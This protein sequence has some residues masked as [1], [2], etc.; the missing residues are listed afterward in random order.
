MKKQ[1]FTAVLLGAAL[2]CALAVPAAAAAPKVDT[3]TC[4]NDYAG[5]LSQETEDYVTGITV[6]LQESCGA[7]IGVYTV[8]NIGNTDLE[9]Y[10]Y[11]VFNA[12]GLGDA[13]EDNGVLLL[14]TPGDDNYICLQGEGLETT[15]SSSTLDTL[16]YSNL[17]PSWLKSDYDTGTRQT[18]RA[19]AEKLGDI[20]QVSIDL[21]GTP[22][23]PAAAG[24][25]GSGGKGG[26]VLPAVV[27]ILVL[28]IVLIVISRPRR[29]PRGPRVFFAPMPRRRR[30]PPPPP[31]PRRG[32]GG[33]GPGPGGYRS[34]PPRSGGFRPGGGSRP[35]GGA[36]RG[37]GGAFRSGGGSSRGGG[38]SRRR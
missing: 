27:L 14:L 10:A 34:G 18:V 11:D 20:Y 28:V 23:G 6:Q 31:P 30:P 24:G 13:K 2:A 17:E 19:L 26:S 16:L 32:P 35:S 12:W 1:H 15:L 7:Q 8:E 22:A 3:S 36:S 37:G 5:I 9:Q 4:V 25:S 38:A 33:F 29:G 21:N